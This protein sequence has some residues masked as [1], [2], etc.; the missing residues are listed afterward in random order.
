M[1]VETLNSE[2]VEQPALGVML[3][4]YFTEPVYQKIGR[5]RALNF[6]PNFVNRPGC[7]RICNE[8][9]QRAR[10]IFKHL[11]KSGTKSFESNV[12]GVL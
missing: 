5:A 1:I 11:R 10:G 9:R 6:N 4:K 7:C 2:V 3:K 8:V 12:G